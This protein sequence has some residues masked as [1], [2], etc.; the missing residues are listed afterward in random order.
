M[1]PLPLQRLPT[2]VELPPV[3]KLESYPLA[4]FLYDRARA[5]YDLELANLR[6]R[7][8]KQSLTEYERDQV[9]RIER[10]FQKKVRA[11]G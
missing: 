3:R 10:L 7:K 4:D 11:S 6:W 1:P 9:E 5:A 2:S 8:F